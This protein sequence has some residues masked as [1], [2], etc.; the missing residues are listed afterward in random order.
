M[1]M[2]D[3]DLIKILIESKKGEEATQIKIHEFSK[4][5]VEILFGIL[6]L[7]KLPLT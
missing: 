6:T 2:N 1:N 3:D 7:L 4:I 5:L